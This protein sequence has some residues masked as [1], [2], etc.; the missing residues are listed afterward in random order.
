MRIFGVNRKE[1]ECMKY[2]LWIKMKKKGKKKQPTKSQTNFLLFVRR[3]MRCVRPCA[4][5]IYHR[6]EQICMM[7]DIL[8]WMYVVYHVFRNVI[9]FLFSIEYLTR[10]LTLVYMLLTC[11]CSTL[12][13]IAHQS[14]RSHE[15]MFMLCGGCLG[16]YY[17]VWK[18]G[19]YIKMSL[20]WFWCDRDYLQTFG[21]I[22]MMCDDFTG[23]CGPPLW[24]LI[25]HQQYFHIWFMFRN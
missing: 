13:V 3:R 25:W 15:V 23:H 17:R 7:Y 6:T 12:N 16:Q 20:H 18:P 2:I 4:H 1:R 5:I 8:L 22:S 19:E 10:I 14:D 9:R 11:C 21:Q 24:L